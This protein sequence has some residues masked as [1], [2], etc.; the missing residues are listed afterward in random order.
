MANRPDA[1][2]SV[3]ASS[4]SVAAGLDLICL[5]SPV[6]QNADCKPRLFGKAADIYAFHGYCE[7]VD[8]AELHIR[9]TRKAVMFVPLPIVT[10][11][12]V[13]RK[14][15]AGNTGSSVV[16]VVAG[17]TGVLGE[18]DGVVKVTKGGTIGTSQIMLSYSLDGGRTFKAYRLGTA[19]SAA[20][21]YF[22]V[23]LT[24]AA[25]TL[26]AGDTVLTWSGSAPRSD[27]AGW[28]LARQKLA[29]QLKL[30]RSAL[31]CGDLQN[32]TEGNALAGVF[33]T[34]ETSNQRFTR[35]RASVLDRLPSAAMSRVQVRMTGSPTL[36][37]T[38]T[39]TITRSAGSW[40][41]DGFAIG[42]TYTIAGSVSNN[43]S[44]VITGLTATTITVASGIVNEGPVSNCTVVGT[45]T[46]TFGA[47]TTATRNR[48]SWLDD[49]FRVGDSV[50]FA[51][52]ASNNVT[53]TITAL[54]ALVMTFAA[55]IASE[56][57]G[58]FGITATTGQTKAVWMAAI[59][60][61][62]AAVD[63]QKRIGLASGRARVINPFT[64][65]YLRRSPAWAASIR[66]Y[67]HDLHRTTW[68]KA[69]GPQVGW[70]LADADGNLVEWDERV[71]NAASAARFTSFT[72]WGNGPE[73][74]FITLSLTREVEGS[75]LQ[76][77]HNLDVANLCCTI[78]QQKTENV[79]GRSDFILND[80]GTA[81]AD[82]LATVA[83]DVNS[84]LEAQILQN[85][86]GEGQRASKVV[87][88]PSTTDLYNV[89]DATMTGVCE[90][91]LNGTVYHVITVVRVR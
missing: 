78:V 7:G 10:A 14:N 36:T 43:G 47:T 4:G 77:D 3:Q 11:G 25:G 63:A 79:V 66:E 56:V 57:I 5:M 6:A 44:K 18:H 46:I 82:S 86:K 29:E 83:L 32:S 60:A 62:F 87:W 23:T 19:N 20:L 58:S 50:T 26:V 40:I 8:Y 76:H 33:N 70:S 22:G 30:F 69:D 65:W 48:G 85:K 53:L 41:A 73:G 37:F 68:Y 35:V 49:G 75:I 15:T 59:D 67:Q 84:E 89:A 24:F 55:G 13:G 17:G 91:L 2:T 38:A 34:Y 16:D 54:T 9:A 81:T 61:A 12:A 80:D 52:T 27:S 21:P 71:D 42:D 72:T 45:P 64:G 1:S 74:P 39:T 28:D 90:L 51:L 31:L 88:T